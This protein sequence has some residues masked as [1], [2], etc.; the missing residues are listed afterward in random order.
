MTFFKKSKRLGLISMTYQL[1]IVLGLFASSAQAASKGLEVDWTK[2]PST[3]NW[4]A[5]FK[6]PDA[7]KAQKWKSLEAKGQSFEALSWE[8][9]LAWVRSCTFA[10]TQDCSRIVQQGLFDKA[11]V[12]RAEAATRLGQ[13]FAKSGNPAAI[14]LLRTAYGVQQNVRAKEPMF[15]QYR[16]LQAL[17]EIG[18]EGQAVGKQ[19]A[20]N[21]NSL[22]KYWTRIASAK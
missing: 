19:L 18:G 13:R 1:V 22:H 10:S 21:S 4:K 14:R 20:M 16:I 5:F 12:V 3:E 8:W 9:K 15:V 6:L 2:A 17:N 11:L 7:E